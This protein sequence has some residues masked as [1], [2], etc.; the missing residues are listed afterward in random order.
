M[1]GM[2]RLC[3]DPTPL[4]NKV[5]DYGSVVSAYLSLKKAASVC[6]H[7]IVVG[8]EKAMY[9]EQVELAHSHLAKFC[10]NLNV[11]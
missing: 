4:Q 8:K 6:H 5:E 10:T 1:Q 7:L 9:I 3:G 2:E 11:L